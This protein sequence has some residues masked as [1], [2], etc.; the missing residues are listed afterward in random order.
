MQRLNQDFYLRNSVDVAKDLLGKIIVREAEG[1]TYPF[2]IVETEAYMGVTDKGAHVFGDK[3][4]GRTWPLYEIGGTTYIYLIYGMYHC[5]NIASNKVGVP[6]CVLIR[7]LEPL[8][9]AALNFAQINRQIRS[10]K[11]QDLTN[12]PGKLCKALKIDKKLNAQSVVKGNELWIGRDETQASFQIV[13]SK[14]INIPYAMEDQH[15]LWRFYI[16]GNS[17]VSVIDKEAKKL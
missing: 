16:Q 12:G 14:R 13:S 8:S 1:H 5:L 10:K 11:V 15:R 7:A 4:T 9:E 3:K 2:K 6:H 17:F